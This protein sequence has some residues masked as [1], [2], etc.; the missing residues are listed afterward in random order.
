MGHKVN[1]TS[2][3]IGTLFDWQSRWFNERTYRDHVKEDVLLRKWLLEKL[4]QAFVSK[5]IIERSMRGITV[6]IHTSR[7]GVIIGR[8]GAGVEE[9][10]KEIARRVAGK[11]QV[12]VNIEE[13]RDP[14]KDAR[15]VALS[16]ADQIEKRMPF[17]RVLKTSVDRV[18]SAGA[19]G[20][21]IAVSGRLNGADMSRSE[22]AV[23]GSVPLH[24][25]RAEIDFARTIAYTTY[26]T[27]GIKVWIYK[28]K[29]FKSERPTAS[30][31]DGQRQL[32]APTRGKREA[33]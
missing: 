14:D 24:T 32:T 15:L 2:F 26:G 12:K 30:A 9:I 4:R 10:R 20:V 3:R 1:P 17:R 5:V 33:N 18:V 22:W 28:G 31:A 23:E 21:R 29:R 8:G 25:L 7:P 11:P 16:V 6:S 13:V 19:E 27:I